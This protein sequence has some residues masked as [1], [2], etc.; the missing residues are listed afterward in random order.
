MYR[1]YAPTTPILS[2]YQR[3]MP[4][5]VHHAKEWL[6]QHYRYIPKLKKTN[7]IQYEKG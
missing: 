3:E 5:Y 6:E 1:L 7:V 4:T 2:I